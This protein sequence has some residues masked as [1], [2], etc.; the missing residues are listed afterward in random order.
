MVILASGS[1]RPP[2]GFAFLPQ[3]LPPP[4]ERTRFRAEKPGPRPFLVFSAQSLGAAA[5]KTWEGR[6][7]PCTASMMRLWQG[8]P[9]RQGPYSLLE[10]WAF[11]EWSCSTDLLTGAGELAAGPMGWL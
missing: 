2:G 5:F 1:L 9:Q 4:G 8:A 6:V 11:L 7:V 10:S 3:W